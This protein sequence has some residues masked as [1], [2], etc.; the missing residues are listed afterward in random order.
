MKKFILVATLATFSAIASPA[1]ESKLTLP[2]AEKI[3]WVCDKASSEDALDPGSA[4]E[5]SVAYEIVLRDKFQ[6]DFSKFLVWW[7]A[8]KK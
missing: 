8:N 4:A 6:G 1:S 5:C 3:F 2:E 7:K